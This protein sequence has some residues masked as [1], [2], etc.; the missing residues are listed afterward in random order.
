MIRQRRQGAATSVYCCW[1]SGAVLLCSFFA[2]FFFFFFSCSLLWG[3]S[4]GFLVLC[5]LFQFCCPIF[6]ASGWF[7]CLCVA[8]F[9]SVFLAFFSR[10]L[11]WFLT[12]CCLFY[13]CI[14]S[15]CTNSWTKLLV[16]YI[17]PTSVGCNLTWS[18]QISNVLV[19]VFTDM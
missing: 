1:L 19:L 18:L 4:S 10:G 7:G 12:P 17:Y 3:S 8:V 6:S 5:F 13:S 14:T 9:F 11:S 15:A 2:L 16:S